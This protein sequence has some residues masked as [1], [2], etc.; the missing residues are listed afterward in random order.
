MTSNSL[1]PRKQSSCFHCK[2]FPSVQMRH[3]QQKR[4]TV[5]ATAHWRQINQIFYLNSKEKSE[6]KEKSPFVSFIISI[7]NKLHFKIHL[8]SL[9]PTV[10]YPAS[11][12]KSHPPVYLPVKQQDSSCHIH[13]KPKHSSLLKENPKSGS[14]YGKERQNGGMRRDW[15]S[16]PQQQKQRK[17]KHL[18]ISFSTQPSPRQEGQPD[19]NQWNKKHSFQNFLSN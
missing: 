11:S 12:S 5:W 17:I 18:C 9:N 4:S 8:K 2:I 14:Q 1:S 15:Q 19:I 3:K 6:R 10:T 7:P 13:T 16:S